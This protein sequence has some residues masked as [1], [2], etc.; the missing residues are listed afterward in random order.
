M[1]ANGMFVLRCATDLIHLEVPELPPDGYK[2]HI[3][4]MF[5]NEFDRLGGA[6]VASGWMQT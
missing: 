6:I 5:C 4:A 1:Y 3:C 2:C